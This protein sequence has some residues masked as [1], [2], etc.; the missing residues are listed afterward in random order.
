LTVSQL[1]DTLQVIPERRSEGLMIEA[2]ILLLANRLAR[3]IE[4]MQRRNRNAR[5]SATR[6]RL[7]ELAELGIDS[8]RFALC[9]QCSL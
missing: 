6:R 9:D 1:A 5:L 8:E 3:D 2:Q 7:R 4:R